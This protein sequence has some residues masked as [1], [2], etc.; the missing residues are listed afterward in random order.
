VNGVEE[1]SLAKTGNINYGLSGSN[2]LTIG[3]WDQ[4]GFLRSFDGKID[5]VQIF[6]TTLTAT[7][8]G[9]LFSTGVASGV[10]V[11]QPLMIGNYPFVNGSP[12]TDYS[13]SDNDG[14]LVGNAS[15]TTTNCQLGGCME[16]DGSGD[17]YQIDGILD[18]MT[19]TRGTVEGWIRTDVLSDYSYLFAHFSTN[20]RIYLYS[21][22]DGSLRTSLGSNLD[23]GISSTLM[24]VGVWYHAAV[25]WE[26]G[27]FSLYLNGV[28]EDSGTYSGLTG[29]GSIAGLGGQA[30]GSQYLN[31]AVDEVH[32]YNRALP[33][34]M[35]LE[36]YNNGIA[37]E[38]GPQEIDSLMTNGGELWSLNVTPIDSLG[39]TIASVDASNTVTITDAFDAAGI[40][41]AGAALDPADP[42]PANCTGTELDL[43]VDIGNQIGASISNLP[44]GSH[45]VY[46]WEREAGVPL[47]SMNLP[48]DSLS[49]GYVQ[50]FSGNGNHA[51]PVGNAT[52][53]T[54]G[55]VGGAIDLDGSAD[56]LRFP[57][58]GTLDAVTVS[59]W[60]Y[61]ESVSGNR[62]VFMIPSDNGTSN[63]ELFMG[64]STAGGDFRIVLNHTTT[65][66]T[67]VDLDLNQWNHMVLTWN[68]S[69][70][71]VFKNGTEVSSFS[72]S[73]QLDFDTCEG[74]IGMDLDNGCTASA[75]DY[76]L[77]QIDEVQVYPFA[78]DADTI[79][80]MYTVSSAGDASPDFFANASNRLGDVWNLPGSVHAIDTATG[81]VGGETASVNTVT[82]EDDFATDGIACLGVATSPTD[83]RPATCAGSETDIADD[84]NSDVGLRVVGSTDG[85]SLAYQWNQSP[86]N[87]LMEVYFPMDS[88]SD[89]ELDDFSGNTAHG[90]PSGNVSYVSDGLVGGALN[91][92]G[93]GDYVSFPVSDTLDTLTMSVSFFPT[94]FAATP[95]VV[96]MPNNGGAANNEF[97]VFVLPSGELRVRMN[98]SITQDTGVSADLNL[99]NHLVVSWDGTTARVYKNGALGDS[100][101]YS[102]QLDFDTCDALLG[103]DTDSGCTGTP[104]NYFSGRIDEFQLYDL[105]LDA[106]TIS[107]MYTNLS[108]GESAPSFIDSSLS[109]LGNQWSVTAHRIAT[110]SGATLAN[111]DS[112]NTVTILSELDAGDVSISNAVGGNVQEDESIES[113]FT[114]PSPWTGGLG[115]QWQV[116]SGSGYEN[117]AAL[118]MPGDAN[119]T[120]I[121]GEGNNGTFVGDTAF[122]TGCQVEGCFTFDGTGDYVDAGNDASLSFG[123][124]ESFTY[125][126]WIFQ[127]SAQ[128]GWRGIVYHGAAGQSQGH[129]GLQTGTR[130]LSGGT[131]DGTTW[132]TQSST[133]APPINT[134]VH[135]AM[136]LDRST[137]ILKLYA[138][139]NEVGSFTHNHVP[140]ATALGLRIGEGNPGSEHFQGRI[141]EVQVYPRAL[142]ADQVAVMYADGTNVDD[143]DRAGP[144]QIVAR[145]HNFGEDWKLFNYEILSDGSAVSPP[146][147]AAN[148]PVSISDAAV[149]TL[150]FVT[151]ASSGFNPDAVSQEMRNGDRVSFTCTNA[152]SN[153]RDILVEYNINGAGFLPATLTSATVVGGSA[154]SISGNTILD[155][156]CASSPDTIGF[157]WD[158]LADGVTV[159]TSNVVLRV[160]ADIN[161]APNDSTL[162]FDVVAP[163]VITSCT[164]QDLSTLGAA[165]TDDIVCDCASGT[166]KADTT[167]PAF[168]AQTYRSLTLNNA[169]TLTQTATGTGSIVKTKLILTEGL[170]IGPSASINMDFT[171]AASGYHIDPDVSETVAQVG[172]RGA[173]GGL[174]A[175]DQTN[176]DW[177]YG[178]ITTPD[179]PG[180]GGTDLS[181]GGYVSLDVGGSFIH[182]GTISATGASNA[183]F[184]DRAGSG[185][186]ILIDVDGEYSGTGIIRA[187]GGFNNFVGLS[188]GGGRIAF[189]YT[190]A[191]S[192]NAT[193]P[194]ETFTIESYSLSGGTSSGGSG[195]IYIEDKNTHTVDE[196]IL[197]LDNNRSNTGTQGAGSG[198]G[199]L[200]APIP[201]GATFEE[202]RITD[203]GRALAE[204]LN[205]KSLFSM[206]DF[207]V[208]SHESHDGT[209]G[210]AGVKTLFI[211]GRVGGIP[212]A[213]VVID[214]TSEIDIDVR[215]YDEDFRGDG[216]GAAVLRAVSGEAGAYGGIGGN[217]DGEVYGSI[218]APVGPGSGGSGNGGAA[219]GGGA[220]RMVVDDLNFDGLISANSLNGN[221]SLEPGSGGAVYIESTGVLS[222]SGS[223]TANGGLDNTTLGVSGGGGRI[224]FY[225]DSDVNDDSTP[226]NT[227]PEVLY[228]LESAS[229][230]GTFIGG[231]GTI[232][233][234]DDDVVLGDVDGEG[235]LIVNGRNGS[236]NYGGQV[237]P[238]FVPAG[239]GGD[240]QYTFED[241]TVINNATLTVDTPGACDLDAVS[242]QHALVVKGSVT[243]TGVTSGSVTPALGD[244]VDGVNAVHCM[245]RPHTYTNIPAG[246]VINVSTARSIWLVGC[247]RSNHQSLIVSG[248]K[249][250]N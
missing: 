179:H 206:T 110:G 26:D 124:G 193:A 118:N 194:E 23:V 66:D 182:D 62:T 197:I 176:V 12:E 168:T 190:T 209:V 128:S 143:D 175:G 107:E 18:D 96:M 216:S 167:G 85:S 5:E 93:S 230:T 77:G 233:I 39:D 42:R 24:T 145:E 83:P 37:Q 78:L 234:E 43:N 119:A 162:D 109:T 22:T 172:G 215:G 56:Y 204:T 113:T 241:V 153:P 136:T 188:A 44:V 225:Y 35:I 111:K 189:K 25:V 99:W 195:T 34:D 231:P 72:Y 46:E 95:A 117:F 229:N 52:Y 211:D 200:G 205:I 63:N 154:L 232:Y 73:G 187:N 203:G 207:A 249:I 30:A 54:S 178:S 151:D 53:T 161:A 80:E 58:P 166:I 32:I 88:L 60:A 245:N 104:G 150:D 15:F 10:S 248:F 133:Y 221:T 29:L 165:S 135:V 222:G 243:T 67:G 180:S 218:T 171:G 139:G 238:L 223:I 226:D 132:Q 28:E 13:G 214:A 76:F 127:S 181:S 147:E 102:G 47:M 16:F 174:P 21:H 219:Y 98:E 191:G 199:S 61:P 120:D 122:A 137:N 192:I 1:N 116:D 51:F 103:M 173:Y 140:A 237:T 163:F 235:D 40:A 196:G 82:I 142:S 6:D 8:I 108:A 14:S 141:D 75:G 71:R 74:V 31:G 177:A 90:T 59:V 48:M 158:Y 184:G 242:N 112:V 125:S 17:I 9:E 38:G 208:I 49:D 20:N 169:C 148:S 7:Q 156:D 94:S 68:G 123:A 41:C 198:T 212:T 50:D 160:T 33:A 155:A 11:S 134:W 106:D 164:G 130:Y 114:E 246:Y 213:D 239:R 36:S 138:D 115:Y 247:S 228:T 79:A 183:L 146:I 170:T 81:I 101:A 144:T 4:S 105:A 157:V 185:G 92:D 45:A 244:G 3:K 19:P 236:T 186:G 100:F 240:T 121:S 227:S 91:F 129:L 55:R 250:N 84:G 217:G 2:D 210:S 70:A 89:S 64:Q 69:L 126:A 159:T 149:T 224:A 27:N 131:G 202:V 152:D 57:N 65:H 86:S 201:D 97:A 87:P 220:L